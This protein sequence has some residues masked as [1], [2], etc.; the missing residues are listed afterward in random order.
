MISV[1]GSWLLTMGFVLAVGCA[2]AAVMSGVGYQMEMWHFRT[3]FQILKWSFIV[4]IAALV[5]SVVGVLAVKKTGT[6][7]TMGILGILISGMMVYVPLSWKK[8]LDAYPYIHDITTDIDNPPQFV[9]VAAVRGP[10]DHPVEYD[11]A[12]VAA[13]QKQAYPDLQPWLTQAAPAEA[14]AAARKVLLRMGLKLV[15]VNESDLR[16]EA[17]ATTLFYGFSDDVVVRMAAS[18][19]GT[20]VDVRSKSRVGRSDLGQNAKRIRTFLAKLKTEIGE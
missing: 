14:F 9:A 7:I 6:A 13:M 1:I 3:G 17:T 19:E 20:R 12:E 4:A 8:T 15:D 16:I 11:G 2:I 10:G 18:P 5:F